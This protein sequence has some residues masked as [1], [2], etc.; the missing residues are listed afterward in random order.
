AGR[1]EN[2]CA[3]VA[4]H[5]KRSIRDIYWC[6]RHPIRGFLW[7]ER[8]DKAQSTKSKRYC[9]QLCQS[10]HSF[11]LFPALDRLLPGSLI[12][13]LKIPSA[14]CEVRGVVFTALRANK[15]LNPQKRRAQQQW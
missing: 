3:D 8:Q 1:A 11:L 7:K 12:I 5:R 10:F 2:G 6:G 14:D 13:D 15:L 4:F 9:E